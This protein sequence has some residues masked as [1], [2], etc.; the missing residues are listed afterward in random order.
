[1]TPSQ[2]QSAVVASALAT[3]AA[4]AEE[5]VVYWVS[6]PVQP[7]ETVMMCGFF[8]QPDAVEIA[9]ERLA[10]RD[11]GKPSEQPWQPLGGKMPEPVNPLQTSETALMFELPEHGAPGVYYYAVHSDATDVSFGR[12]NAPVPWWTLG[13]VVATDTPFGKWRLE[14]GAVYAGGRL[15]ILGRCLKLGEKGPTVALRSEDG[16]VTLLQPEK[17]EPFSL[18]VTVPEGLAPGRYE[19]FVHNGYGGAARLERTTRH[20]G[21]APGGGRPT[22]DRGG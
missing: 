8:P 12:L 16:R 14:D 1:M 10:D 13:D 22:P 6:A 20:C 11:P 5:N 3:S 21:P 7:G 19:L 4:L 17:A 9:V 18:A 2:L 15:R